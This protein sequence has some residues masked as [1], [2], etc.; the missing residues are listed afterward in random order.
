MIR[1][2]FSSLLLL[3]MAAACT[4]DIDVKLDTAYARLVVDGSIQADTGVFKTV[5]TSTSGYFSN[6]SAPKVVNA[7]VSLTDGIHSWPMHE[8][9][10]GESGVYQTDSTFIGMTDKTYTLSIDLA[11]PIGESSHFEATSKLNHV[12]RLDSIQA[13]FHPEW[14]KDGIWSVR[15]WA[16]EPGDEENYYMFNLYK[17]G[18]LLTDTLNKKT[19]TE[20]RFVNG[21]YM[22]GVDVMYL[23]NHHS[24]ESLKPGDVI[25]LQM[26]AITKEY[27]NF[28]NQV[29]QSGFSIPFFSGPPANVQGNIS[30]GGVG[31]FIAMA[32]SY[33]SCVVKK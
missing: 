16:Q 21:S 9:N 19:V 2:Y 22:N 17:N 10:P 12:T 33:K 31:F 1:T 7:S 15:L 18:V 4:E 32:S 13:V 5:L 14:G 30:N 24:W 27:F 28:V 29:K 3:L 26:S 23:N 20:D 11:E 8:S 6:T 25:I